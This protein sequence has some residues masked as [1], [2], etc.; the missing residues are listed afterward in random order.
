MASAPEVERPS[1]P[2]VAA[3][4]T[5]RLPRLSVPMRPRARRTAVSI[6]IPLAITLLCWRTLQLQPLPGLDLSWQAA[7]H[8]AQHL[9]LQFGRQIVFTYGP[10]GFLGFPT[11]W[12]GDTG[13]AA[14]VYTILL[15]FSV[16]AAL[17]WAARRTYGTVGGAIVALLAAGA[18]AEVNETVPFFV[19]CVWMVDRAAPARQRLALMA[20]GGGVAGVE[21][22]NKVSVGMELTALAI[23][24]ALA[25]R[26]RRRD[27]LLVTLGAL[28]LALLVAWLAAGQ[29]L[30]SLPAY[31]HNS[32]RIVSGYAGAMSL[33]EP[34]VT[35][36]YTAGWIAFAFGLA[37]AWQM[38]AVGSTRRR[39]GIVA[40]WLVFC[41]FEFKEGFVRHETG[42]GTIYF[43]ALMGGFLAFRW[44]RANRLVGIGL[45]AALFAFALA[46]QHGTLST[47][48]APVR[49]AET[50]VSQIE[51]VTSSHQRAAITA[52]GREEIK[53]AL[54]IDP[55]TLRLL[56]GHTVD[57]LPDEESVA[58]AYNLDWRPLPI[59]QNYS[60]YTTGLDQVNAEMLS[61]AR[62]PQRILRHL[63]G[64]IDNR[65]GAFTEGLTTRTILCSYE[66]L[67]TTSMWQVLGLGPNRCGAP[68]PLGTISAGWD[69]AVAVPAPPNEDSFVFVRIGG[70]GV[71]G[72][73]RLYG[74]LYRPV[75][76]TVV[77][78]GTTYRLIEA[79][80]S[81]G[82]IL[83]A[84]PGVDFSP[85]FNL[86]P[87][88]TMIAVGENGQG[89]TRDHQ[90]TFSFYAQP[91]SFGPRDLS[92]QRAIEGG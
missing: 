17:F 60:A 5:V 90:I 79:T 30:G 48:F 41:F 83:R 19:F 57:V 71:G 36:Q 26:G 8:M 43:V 56:R 92:L 66:E 84:P 89:P 20:I 65:V 78:N 25:A 54:P 73:E 91:V 40:L 33:E 24:M 23:V 31:L 85:P 46:A 35:W 10:L 15:Y 50:A 42:H 75:G 21:L 88:A 47:A 55:E 81:D 7:L 61:S 58:W 3:Q 2:A 62:A 29:A 70:A 69:Q 77:L 28:V 34:L 39:W 12:Y 13:A 6:L 52:A 49:D 22:L 16:A 32:A 51:D 63:E 18:S 74:L 76:R 59:F 9:N 14:V 86:A 38:T 53:Q 11:L 37:G 82:L 67:R 64:E 72:L 27:Q 87:N 4:P 80:A 45:A 1:A 44:R 68:V